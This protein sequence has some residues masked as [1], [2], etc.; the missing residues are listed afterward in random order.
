ML[1]VIAQGLLAQRHCPQ[2]GIG[3]SPS[4]KAVTSY[5]EADDK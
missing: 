4:A 5:E 1:D 2:V 3:R